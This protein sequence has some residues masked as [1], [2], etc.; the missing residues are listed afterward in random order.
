MS[1]WAALVPTMGSRSERGYIFMV[2]EFW[3]LLR[4]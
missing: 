3:I 4:V 1:P 2:K